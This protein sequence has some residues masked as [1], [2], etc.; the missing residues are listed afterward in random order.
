MAISEQVSEFAGYTVKD[1][2]PAVGIILP[3]VMPRRE[4]RERD[5]K[6]DQFWA[7]TLEGDRHTVQSGTVGTDGQTDTQQFPTVAQAQASYRKLIAQRVRDGYIVVLPEREFQ[8]VE[9]KSAKFW[10]IEVLGKRTTVRFGRIG[11]AGQMHVK[12]HDTEAESRRAAEKLIAEKTAK[13]YAEKAP[14]AGTLLDALYSTL[15]ANPDDQVTR[16]ALADYLSEQGEH[17]P[18]VAYRVNGESNREQLEAFLADPFAG[19]VEAARDRL[20]LRHGRRRLRGGCKG[21][22]TGPRPSAQ[23]PRSVHR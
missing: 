10:A 14:R 20:L 2:D 17:L 6:S 15:L 5:A 9:G 7:I 11:T 16:M 18:P 8:L 3:A 22:G 4:F 19:F 23:S 12:E 21:P 1:Y 13:G